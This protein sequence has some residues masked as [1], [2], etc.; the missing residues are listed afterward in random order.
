M[1]VIRISNDSF[2]S[3]PVFPLQ[4][5][6]LFPHTVLPLHVFEPRYI[7][8]VDYAIEHN[9]LITLADVSTVSDGD[10]S[11]AEPQLRPILGAGVIILKRD[12][13]GGR[14]QLLVQGVSRVFM[15]EELDQQHSFR[16]VRAELMVDEEVN[17]DE[18]TKLEGQLRSLMFGYAEQHPKQADK[19]YAILESAPD[20]SVLGHMLSA[21][22]IKDP[23]HKRVLFEDLNPLRRAQNVYQFI[24][25]IFVNGDV[26]STM[27]WH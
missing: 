23:Q 1:P 16:Q 21:H 13:P 2:Q 12:L 5:V 10:E 22:L 9:H 24:S 11:E 4:G 18:L 25:D 3:V 14:Y 19:I 17:A 7:E 20:A 8:M 15:L 6:Q 27:T 26:E